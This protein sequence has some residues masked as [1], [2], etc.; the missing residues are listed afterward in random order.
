VA[1]FD[2]RAFTTRLLPLPGLY[3]ALRERTDFSGIEL[4]LEGA[5]VHGDR[6]LLVQRG[7]AGAGAC[8][9]IAT[10]A[11][12]DVEACILGDFARRPPIA[13]VTGYELGEHAGVR[14]TFTDICAA[15]NETLVYLATAEAS[16]DVTRDG[17]VAGSQ[18]GVVTADSVRC[19]ALTDAQGRPF[20]DKPEGVVLDPQ[21]PQHAWIVVDADDPARPS[22]L[23]EVELSGPWY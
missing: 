13:R 7:N 15:P 23:C 10:L 6:L 1:S 17:P 11:W 2:G 22:E 9:A 16:P 19:A 18:I 8:D 5:L 12:S 4:N 3:A 21:R 20:S 14:L